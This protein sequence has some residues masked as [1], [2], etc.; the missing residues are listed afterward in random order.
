MLYTHVA[1]AIGGLVVA[2][3]ATWQVQTWRYTHIV[4]KIEQKHTEQLRQSLV[5]AQENFQR[6]N[7]ASAKAE[8]RAVAAKRDADNAKSELERL[9]HTLA[10][11]SPT[12]PACAPCVDRTNTI[13][14]LFGQCAIALEELAGKADR[15]TNDI[16]TLREAW[17]K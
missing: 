1:A 12:T 9:R 16:Q 10:P 17:P 6:V 14:Q 11:I 8:K 2:A 3:V 5:K 15:H 4:A 7:D 13:S